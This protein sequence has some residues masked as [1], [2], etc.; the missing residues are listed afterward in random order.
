M[1]VRKCRAPQRPREC[2]ASHQYRDLASATD[3]TRYPIPRVTL[4][5]VDR[6]HEQS[7]QRT[8]RGADRRMATA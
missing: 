5:L 1:I 2:P 6:V 8:D 4:M 3:C 7:G